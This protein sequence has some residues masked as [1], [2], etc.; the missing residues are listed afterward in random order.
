MVKLILKKWFFK[1]VLIFL[2]TYLYMYLYTPQIC[3]SVYTHYEGKH[4]FSS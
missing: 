4:K 1:V 2:H 3:D